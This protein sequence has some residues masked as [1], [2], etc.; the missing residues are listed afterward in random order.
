MTKKKDEYVGT[1]EYEQ[2]RAAFRGS[3][4]VDEAPYQDGD[5]NLEAWKAGYEFEKA[6]HGLVEGRESTE[7]E[8]AKVEHSARATSSALKGKKNG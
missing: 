2:G 4:S 6:A 1:P 7:G 8:P 3:I 5:H